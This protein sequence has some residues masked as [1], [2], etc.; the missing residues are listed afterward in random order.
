[1]SWYNKNDKMLPPF[2]W[3]N[4]TIIFHDQTISYIENLSIILSKYFVITV[5]VRIVKRRRRS[6]IY[7]E[8]YYLPQHDAVYIIYRLAF[9][10]IT[11]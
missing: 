9:Y 3:S 4:N 2:R 10:I 8:T 1:M 5:P 11:F 7:L 6:D